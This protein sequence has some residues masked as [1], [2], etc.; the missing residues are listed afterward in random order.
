[1]EEAAELGNYLPRSFNRPNEQEY[2]AFLWDGSPREIE[3]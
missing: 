3:S 1:M 2:V